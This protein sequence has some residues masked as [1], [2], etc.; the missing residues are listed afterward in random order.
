MEYGGSLLCPQQPGTCTYS[1]TNKSSLSLYYIFIRS[2]LLVLCH[3]HLGVPSCRLPS[4]FFTKTLFS[5]VRD[6]CP[7]H[8]I[9]RQLVALISLGAFGSQA[10]LLVTPVRIPVSAWMFVC[11][12]CCLLSG[13]CNWLN[14]RSEESCRLCV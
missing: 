3:L 7:T 1:E 13:F 14:P 9:F 2:I 8:L 5:P 6:V 10:L 11:R 12:V 4:A